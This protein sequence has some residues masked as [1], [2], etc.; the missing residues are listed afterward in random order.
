M[1]GD[2]F[3]AH[4][5][6]AKTEQEGGGDVFAQPYRAKQLFEFDGLEWGNTTPTD[7]DFCLEFKDKVWVLI[8][9]KHNDTFFPKGQRLLMERF[10]NMCRIAGKHGIAMVVAHHVHDWRESVYVKDCEV[11]EYYTTETGRWAY[12]RRPYF[13]QEMVT[14]YLKMY[15]GYE[16]GQDANYLQTNRRSV[17]V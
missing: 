16:H 6:Y 17:A 4:F 7:L 10:I 11:R 5:H 9:V 8:E 14:E 15:G 2:W 3:T 1:G 13:V 12:P